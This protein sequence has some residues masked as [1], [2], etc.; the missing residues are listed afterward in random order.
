MVVESP[1]GIGSQRVSSGSMAGL[2]QTLGVDARAAGNAAGK[3]AVASRSAFAGATPNGPR[4]RR[5]LAADTPVEK[6]DR[7]AP[8]GSYLD[9]LV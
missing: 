5:M 1:N 3:A 7:S 8:R 6:L 4:G 9:I 2:R